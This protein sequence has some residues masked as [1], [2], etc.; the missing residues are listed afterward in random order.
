[1]DAGLGRRYGACRHQLG[2]HRVV[3]GQLLEGGAD[4]ITALL[5][6]CHQE[7]DLPDH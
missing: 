2:D 6:Y 7:G 4:N 5:L 1:M 3:L